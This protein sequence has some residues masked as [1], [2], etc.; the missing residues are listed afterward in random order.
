M[1]LRTRDPGSVALELDAQLTVTPEIQVSY[2][3]PYWEAL[4][5]VGVNTSP[6]GK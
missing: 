4:D 2:K 5:A 1:I 6:D 3:T